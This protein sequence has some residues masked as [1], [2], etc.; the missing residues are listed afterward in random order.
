MGNSLRQLN[1][2]GQSVWLD[3]L[4]HKL[5]DS[6]ELQRWVSE[7]AITGVTSNPTI[8]QK[9]IVGSSDYDSRL[10]ALLK[11]G[12]RAEKE[13]FFGLALDDIADAAS[14]LRPVFDATAGQDGFVSIE[15]S[16]DIAYDTA[17]TVAE[18]R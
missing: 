12:M 17:A 7:D 6:G 3:N 2:A 4:S 10:R 18:A 16:P 9:A 1:R 8:F 13:L 11:G 14:V 15:V 5:V